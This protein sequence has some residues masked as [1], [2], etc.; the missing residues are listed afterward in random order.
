MNKMLKKI[1]DEIGEIET[2]L[3][4]IKMAK[5]NCTCYGSTPHYHELVMD[6]DSSNEYVAESEK[7][8]LGYID[9]LKE[10]LKIL[11]KR[12]KPLNSK[13]KERR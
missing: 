12:L 10:R 1:N 2:N 7:V 5:M 3:A 11:R 4:V 6:G 8:H 13:S 9:G